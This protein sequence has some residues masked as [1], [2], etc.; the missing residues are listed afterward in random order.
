MERELYANLPNGCYEMKYEHLHD[1]RE[2]LIDAFLT[3]NKIWSS[4]KMSREQLKEFFTNVILDHFDS[5]NRVR[6]TILPNAVINFV[7]FRLCRFMSL[8]V[9]LW[10]ASCIT[11]SKS[12]GKSKE[13]TRNPQLLFSRS[14]REREGNWWNVW[15]WTDLRQESISIAPGPPT[16]RIPT[17]IRWERSRKLLRFMIESD[18]KDFRVWFVGVPI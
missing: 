10:A 3:N 5:Q 11:K 9:N 6:Q 18:P 2:L 1:V 8:M 17:T 7:P 16:F 13:T 4:A 15:I 14:F 12:I